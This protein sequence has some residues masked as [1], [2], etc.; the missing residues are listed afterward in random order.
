VICVN[1]RKSAFRD[2][3][4]PAAIRVPSRTSSAKIRISSHPATASIRI[5]W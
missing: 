5:R 4:D 2:L 3:R 1:P